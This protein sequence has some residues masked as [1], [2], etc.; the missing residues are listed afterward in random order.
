MEYYIAAF[1]LICAI[2]YFTFTRCLKRPKGW[3]KVNSDMEGNLKIALK[4]DDFHPSNTNFIPID[5][6]NY[7]IMTIKNNIRNRNILSS[8]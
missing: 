2:S 7:Y 3:F 1:F 4:G 5:E 6:E 8:L